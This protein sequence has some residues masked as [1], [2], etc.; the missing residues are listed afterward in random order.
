MVPQEFNFK[1]YYLN[2]SLTINEFIFIKALTSPPHKYYQ[3]DITQADG[4]VVVNTD[5]EVMVFITLVSYSTITS[6]P[7]SLE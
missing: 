6:G 5:Q 7:T 1:R 4:G 3:L 2:I